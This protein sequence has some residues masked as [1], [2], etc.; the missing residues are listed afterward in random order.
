MECVNVSLNLLFTS[1]TP[2]LTSAAFVASTVLPPLSDSRNVYLSR[3]EVSFSLCN[4]REK[5]ASL[6]SLA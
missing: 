5:E 1:P 6:C 2:Q 4:V 3:Q